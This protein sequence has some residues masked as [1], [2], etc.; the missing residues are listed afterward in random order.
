P[1]EV[2][3]VASVTSPGN[4]ENVAGGGDCA[5]SQSAAKTKRMLR[6]AI[7]TRGVCCRLGRVARDGDDTPFTI[8]LSNEK[9]PS[10]MSVDGFLLD[11][12]NH[13]GNQ[14][15]T[16][17]TIGFGALNPRNLSHFP[18][19]DFPNFHVSGFAFQQ[20]LYLIP[21]LFTN[22]GSIETFFD[23]EAIQ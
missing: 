2:P 19:W 16:K 9:P 1:P 14:T 8:L 3:I 4:S 12:Q 17:R 20:G 7:F 11:P 10:S 13:F 6:A 23:V 22:F 5:R 18:G 21:I 15:I